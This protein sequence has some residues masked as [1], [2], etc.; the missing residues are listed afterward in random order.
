MPWYAPR[1]KKLMPGLRKLH[2][3][4]NSA[5][6]SDQSVRGTPG[7]SVSPI[8]DHQTFRATSGETRRRRGMARYGSLAKAFLAKNLTVERLRSMDRL[9][10]EMQPAIMA[11]APGIRS[12][13]RKTE[14]LAQNPQAHA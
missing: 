7:T 1:S 6:S 2:R 9:N 3:N 4:C 10:S 12:L 8:Y 14:R 5:R 11:Q 13:Q